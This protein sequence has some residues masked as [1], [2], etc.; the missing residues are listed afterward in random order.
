MDQIEVKMNRTEFL[1]KMGLGGAALVAVYCSGCSVNNVTPTPSGSVDFT[2]D[3]TA[4]ANAA[5]NTVG[6]YVISNRVVVAKIPTGEFVAVTQVCSHEGRANVTYLKSS[7][8]FYC[9]VH[10]ATYDTTGKGLNSDGRNGLTTYKTSLSGSSL[11][12][13]S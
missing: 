11:R 2:L 7:N 1:K 8:V 13:Y 9:N 6:G 5:L 10:G 3:L 4:S 12:V